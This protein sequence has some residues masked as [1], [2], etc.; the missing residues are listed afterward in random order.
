MNR[1]LWDILLVVWLAVV[2]GAFF[3]AAS[4]LFTL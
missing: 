4:L 1:N 3:Q 2:F